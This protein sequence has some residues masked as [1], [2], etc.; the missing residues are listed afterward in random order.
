MYA[1]ITIIALFAAGLAILAIGSPFGAV[2]M[3]MGAI[4][5]SV[6]LGMQVTTHERDDRVRVR[7]GLER[8]R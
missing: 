6:K 5:V 1:W 8:K 3:V 2:F 7:T 4:V